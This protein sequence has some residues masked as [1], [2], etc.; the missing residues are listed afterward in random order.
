MLRLK[1][2]EKIVYF[3]RRGFDL[4]NTR[5]FVLPFVPSNEESRGIAGFLPH[6]TRIHP[7]KQTAEEV[8]AW[9][10]NEDW[11]IL[12]NEAAYPRAWVVHEARRIEPIRGKNKAD[13]R[14]WMEEI[15]Y[16]ADVFW[17]SPGRL[18]YDPRRLA[19]IETDDW[20]SVLPYLSGGETLPSE[21]VSVSRYEPQR[22]ELDAT[23][24]RPG[25]IVLADV[26]YPGWRLEINGTEAPI[27]LANRAMRGALVKAGKSHL[28]FTYE[29][30]SFRVG[31][32]LSGVGTVILVGC[33]FWSWRR[34]VSPVDAEP[35]NIG[36]GMS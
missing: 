29:P 25:V 7:P 24:E 13:R 10:K 18:L 20:A 3:P 11:Q 8:Q 19:W 26:S 22:V 21:T 32:I 33:L 5:Y 34:P 16:Q 12:K 2:D 4:W 15:L 23:L 9:A 1:K 6:A 14:P 28:V 17:N 31:I 27:L 30:R 35:S 36:E